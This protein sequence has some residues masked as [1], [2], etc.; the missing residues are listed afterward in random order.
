MHYYSCKATPHPKISWTNR[1]T[2]VG[3][4]LR[5]FRSI[6][7]LVIYH[8]AISN[9]QQQRNFEWRFYLDMTTACH[10]CHSPKNLL[11]PIDRH[12]TPCVR[13]MQSMDSVV[14]FT[15][16]CYRQCRHCRRI[17]NIETFSFDVFKC[18]DIVVYLHIKILGYY[19]IFGGDA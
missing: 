5:P 14:L 17:N 19:I 18:L 16:R 4:I 10:N 8:C 15:R 1:I 13:H 2:S 6:Y 9:H 12:L 11:S 3:I 7:V